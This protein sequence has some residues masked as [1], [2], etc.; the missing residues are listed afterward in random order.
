MIDYKLLNKVSIRNLNPKSDFHDICKIML[1]RL[2]RRKYPNCPV[3]TEYKLSGEI[4][5]IYLET[6]KGIIIWELQWNVTK[7]WLEK[8]KKRYSDVD[9]IIVKLKDLPKDF[10]KLKKELEKYV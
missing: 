6:K 10:D 1:Y 5:D 2:I 4:P 3:Y 9:L 8:I 7:K